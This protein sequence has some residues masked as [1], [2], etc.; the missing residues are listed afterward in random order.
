[1]GL[2]PF[3]MQSPRKNRSLSALCPQYFYIIAYLVKNKAFLASTVNINF[4]LIDMDDQ[5]KSL[6]EEAEKPCL[7]LRL[8]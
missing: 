5:C 6:N 3:K 8:R 7:A 2:S 1:M 4:S